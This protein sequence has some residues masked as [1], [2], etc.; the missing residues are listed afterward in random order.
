[1]VLLFLP[2]DR[3]PL[4]REGDGQLVKVGDLGRIELLGAGGNRQLNLSAATS[5]PVFQLLTSIVYCGDPAILLL[6]I[7]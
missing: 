7:T 4:D 2:L 5:A 6:V 1:M 3:L